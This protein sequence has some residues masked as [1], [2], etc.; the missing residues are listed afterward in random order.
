MR[1]N[2][3]SE[4]PRAR[5]SSCARARSGLRNSISSARR[6]MRHT[7]P[8]TGQIDTR[9][10]VIIALTSLLWT[11]GWT[12]SV[13]AA[14]LD[15][16]TIFGSQASVTASAV[17]SAGNVYIAG[18]TASPNLPVTPHAFQKT[19]IQAQCGTSTSPGF[20][21]LPPQPIP[22]THAFV[23]KIDPS[24]KTLLYLTYL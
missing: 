3:A 14:P 12:V 19:F 22:C 10:R 7:N 9:P 18:S 16:Q 15:Y 1:V 23:A 6:G 24:G 2:M 5:S 20:P 8:A 21:P 13:F 4:I 17:D 11:F